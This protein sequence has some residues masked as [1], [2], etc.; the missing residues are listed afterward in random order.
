MDSSLY[1]DFLI[2]LKACVTVISLL[3]L[4]SL[5]NNETFMTTINIHSL[6][7]FHIHYIMY[8]V[9]MGLVILLLFFFLFYKIFL[10]KM[11]FMRD[12]LKG[13]ILTTFLPFFIIVGKG[14]KLQHLRQH[15]SSTSFIF[16]YKGSNA[17]RYNF[18]AVLITCINLNIS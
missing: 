18:R 17:K 6:Q 15:L 13:D 2:L 4:D 16:V 11:K 14:K 9:A 1:K 5:S 8:V 7:G 3:I 10:F 12:Y